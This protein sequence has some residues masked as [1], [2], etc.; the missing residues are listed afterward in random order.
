VAAD[1][2]LP[3]QHDDAVAGLLLEEAVGRGEPDDAPTDDGDID[4]DVGRGRG[5]PAGGLRHVCFRRRG[6]PRPPW[7]FSTTLAD[8]LAVE[9]VFGYHHLLLQRDACAPQRRVASHPGTD[10]CV[11]SGPVAGVVEV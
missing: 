8:K 9:Q 5:A 7:R 6:Q 1:L 11:R 3:L 4:I 2:R 10:R